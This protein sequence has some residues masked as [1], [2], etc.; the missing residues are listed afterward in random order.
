[1][2]NMTCSNGPNCQ[3]TICIFTHPHEVE[4]TCDDVVCSCEDNIVPQFIVERDD[5]YY[6]LVSIFFV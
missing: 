3:N 2:G 6:K 4:C 5:D 1:M